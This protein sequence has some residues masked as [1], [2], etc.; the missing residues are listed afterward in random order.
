MGPS[1]S[2]S[3]VSGLVVFRCVD[4]GEGEVPISEGVVTLMW[5]WGV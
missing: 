5:S 4:R 3:A 1:V 2:A